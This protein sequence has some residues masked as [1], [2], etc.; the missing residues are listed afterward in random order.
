MI[1]VTMFMMIVVIQED[2]DVH[3]DCGDD[4]DNDDAKI[5]VIQEDEDVHDDCGDHDDHDDQGDPRG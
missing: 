3:D 1:V 5:K 2:Q 4:Y